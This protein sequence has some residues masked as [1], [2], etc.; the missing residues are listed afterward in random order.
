[1]GW[2]LCRILWKHPIDF[3]IIQFFSPSN[4]RIHMSISG[5]EN[6]E[7]SMLPGFLARRGWHESEWEGWSFTLASVGVKGH[8]GL[9]L[10]CNE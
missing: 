1:M 5:A 3:T 2:R 7:N 4:T 10:G 8:T 9:I 6:I